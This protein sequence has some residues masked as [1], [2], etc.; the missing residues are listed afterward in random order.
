MPQFDPSSFPSQI[1][2]LVVTFIALYWVVSRLAIPRVGEVIEQRKRL[3]QDDID[4]AQA[5]KTETDQA[6]AAYEKAMADARAQAQDHVRAI[7]AEMKAA[8]D[9]KTAEVN[10][11]V[12]TKI[13]E[14]EARIAKAKSDAMGSLRTIAAETARDIVSKL[15]SLTPDAGAVDAAVGNALKE[16][17]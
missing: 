5:L 10:A 7:T 16:S 9:K 11:E 3:V 6:I 8:A 17:R 15:A 14:G 13:S 4:R 2:W 1:F 12:S